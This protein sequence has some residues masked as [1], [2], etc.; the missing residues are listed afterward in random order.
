MRWLRADRPGVFKALD[1]ANALVRDAVSVLV[2]AS[3]YPEIPEEELQS[4]DRRIRVAAEVV[5]ELLTDIEDRAEAAYWSMPRDA[6]RGSPTA[7][8]VPA[9]RIA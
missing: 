5:L 2:S 7:V 6:K 1:R 9:A 3:S 4:I 8:K